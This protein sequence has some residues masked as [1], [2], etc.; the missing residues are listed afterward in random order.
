MKFLIDNA[1]S[2]DVSEGLRNAGY[3]AVHVTDYSLGE[4]D[5]TI[6]MR[7]AAQEDRI[8]IS[9]DTDFGTLL[10]LQQDTKPYY[11]LS[12][13]LTPPSRSTNYTAY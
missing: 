3:D 7:R 10:A 2:P 5:D 6:I 4:A 9:A 1:L 8:V 11:P 12:Q 13:R